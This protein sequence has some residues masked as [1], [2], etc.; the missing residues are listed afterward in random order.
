MDRKGNGGQARHER[1]TAWP[2][3]AHRTVSERPARADYRADAPESP[4]GMQVPGPEALVN[5]NAQTPALGGMVRS[6]WPNE[7]PGERDCA[8]LCSS[9]SESWESLGGLESQGEAGLAG[10]ERS[11]C[12]QSLHLFCVRLGDVLL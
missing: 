4:P 5:Q 3:P 9:K 8:N 11:P 1:S 10:I 7:R 2:P 6:A 12:F